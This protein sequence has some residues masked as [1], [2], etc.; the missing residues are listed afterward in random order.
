MHSAV[1]CNYRYVN[2]F[3]ALLVKLGLDFNDI[4]LKELLIY[5][6]SRPDILFV[7]M[8]WGAS[9]FLVEDDLQDETG[10]DAYPKDETAYGYASNFKGLTDDIDVILIMQTLASG[11]TVR[12]LGVSSFI[13]LLNSDWLR[14]LKHMLFSNGEYR[15]VDE[16]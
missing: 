16:A 11:R 8:R 3:I 7:M 6:G 15:R 13:R 2:D 1:R 5:P 9:P 4:Q 14:L 10:Y 12:R